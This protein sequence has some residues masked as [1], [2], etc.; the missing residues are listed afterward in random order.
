MSQVSCL[1]G[2][3]KKWYLV[4][5]YDI[6]WIFPHDLML[7]QCDEMLQISSCLSEI[8]LICI[9]I[10]VMSEPLLFGEDSDY[11]LPHLK[12]LAPN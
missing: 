10:S 2:R 1:N 6:V 4:Y 5:V 12:C 7:L 3:S 8:L 11:F 9:G